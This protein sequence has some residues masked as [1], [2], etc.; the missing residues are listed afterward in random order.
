MKGVCFVPHIRHIIVAYK[1]IYISLVTLDNK[2]PF[3]SIS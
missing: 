2:V 3:V 1:N